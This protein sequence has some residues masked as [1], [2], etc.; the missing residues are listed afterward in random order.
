MATIL[1]KYLKNKHN[2]RKEN[3]ASQKPEGFVE[4]TPSPGRQPDSHD[5]SETSGPRAEA[6]KP[7][8]HGNTAAD[9]PPGHGNK[10][11]ARAAR[12]YRFKIIGGLFLP[13]LVQS[14]DTT[15]IAGALPFIASDFSMSMIFSRCETLLT[16]CQINS[17]S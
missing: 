14:L 11:E 7:N 1:Y 3:A 9:T 10:D 2:K 15:I 13:F 17:P 16:Y 8:I 4:L 12:I 5:T 6:E